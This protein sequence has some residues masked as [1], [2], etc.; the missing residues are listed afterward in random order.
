MSQEPLDGNIPTPPF[1]DLIKVSPE[2][3]NEFDISCEKF[4]E[5]LLKVAGKT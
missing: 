1:I 3:A 2:I 4:I 5:C